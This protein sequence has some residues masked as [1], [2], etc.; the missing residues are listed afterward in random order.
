M[1]EDGRRRKQT[2]TKKYPGQLLQPYNAIARNSLC[3]DRINLRD[4]LYEACWFSGI[5]C[6]AWDRLNAMGPFTESSVSGSSRRVWSQHSWLRA[7]SS[8]LSREVVKHISS[9]SDSASYDRAGSNDSIRFLLERSPE[10]TRVSPALILGT[11]SHVRDAVVRRSSRVSN[12][13]H[14]AIAIPYSS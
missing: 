12:S 5:S 4:T 10:N 7:F 9:T 2:R 13:R 14:D 1:Q 11:R 6:D 3:A 8:D